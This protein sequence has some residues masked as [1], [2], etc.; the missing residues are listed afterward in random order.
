MTGYE[1]TAIALRIHATD[2]GAAKGL[3]VLFCSF[4]SEGGQVFPSGKLLMAR[5]GIS[6]TSLTTYIK[7]L[8]KAGLMDV[9]R[10]P[11][12]TSLYRLNVSAIKAAAA[13]SAEVEEGWRTDGDEEPGSL[14]FGGPEPPEQLEPQILGNRIPKFRGDSP[15]IL[16]TSKSVNKPEEQTRG[17]EIM[18]T[19]KVELDFSPLNM[20]PEL[21]DE[22]KA[23]RKAKKAPITQLVINILGKQFAECRAAGA[24]DEQIIEEWALRGWQGFKADW[25]LR[26]FKSPGQG[27]A[28]TTSRP[29][30]YQQQMADQEAMKARFLG[31]DQ[32]HGY[33]YEHE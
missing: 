26:D 18:A 16:G 33:T 3:L 20:A 6:E 31:T 14:D 10:R 17:K 25:F 15:Q 24:T 13:K 27:I 1:L 12:K 2:L 9:K 7:R 29:T 4:W 8:E 5:A 19:Q 32:H 30:K 28:Q 21:V 22:V 23:I 11:N